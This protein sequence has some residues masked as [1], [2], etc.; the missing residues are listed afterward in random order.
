MVSSDLISFIYIELLVILFSFKFEREHRKFYLK[1][2]KEIEETKNDRRT[3]K[4]NQ[5]KWT[6]HSRV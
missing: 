4:S 2:V 5:F 3:T 1:T 6:L